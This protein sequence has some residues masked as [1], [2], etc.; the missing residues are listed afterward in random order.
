MRQEA[1]GKITYFPLDGPDC[2][3]SVGW[4][5]E[6]PRNS[7]NVM[8]MVFRGGPKDPW[9]MVVR[10]RFYEDDNVGELSKD[11]RTGAMTV[12]TADE[13]G[14]KELIARTDGIFK[15]FKDGGI[16]ELYRLERTGPAREFLEEWVKLP[17][18]HMS[19]QEAPQ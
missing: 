9:K 12:A 17:F 19:V 11:R 7:G 6:L 10:A 15:V 16:G 1:D 5:L 4:Y 13:E 3:V 18:V 2:E 8:A 14:R